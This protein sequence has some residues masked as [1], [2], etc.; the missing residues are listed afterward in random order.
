MYEGK[1]LIYSFLPFLPSLQFKKAFINLIENFYLGSTPKPYLAMLSITSKCPFNC[2]YCS[3]KAFH[4]GELKR[5]EVVE[6]LKK[7]KKMQITMISLTGG[8]PLLVDYLPDVIKQFSKDFVFQILTSG[9][10]LD[11]HYARDLK[12]AGLSGFGFSLDT[13]NSE[14]FNRIRGGK[15][16]FEKALEA[17]EISKRT[18]IYTMVNAVITKDKAN[19]EFLDRFLKFLKNLEVD[20]VRFLEPLPCGELTHRPVELF[21]PEHLK[22]LI[23]IQRIAC[24]NRAY[25]KVTSLPYIESLW[26]CGAGNQHVY[27]DPQGFLHPCNFYASSLGNILRDDFDKIVQ[28][29]N[30]LGKFEKNFLCKKERRIYEKELYIRDRSLCASESDKIRKN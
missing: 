3:S 15:L 9:Y 12:K 18:G 20:E 21:D 24:R 13:F 27:I 4:E 11:E 19:F 14:E 10:S 8:E 16:A 26:G 23:E 30:K 29:L 1:F 6:I 28:N 17:I 22:I 5:K 2:F 7:L 25:P